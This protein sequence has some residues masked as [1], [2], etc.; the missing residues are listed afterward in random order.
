MSAPLEFFSIFDGQESVTYTPAVD[1]PVEGVLALRRPLTQSRM[2]NVERYV[3]LQATDV[4]FYLEGG[5]L[6]DVALAAGDSL[7]DDNGVAYQV[8]YV[9][10]QSLK[11]LV[12][13]VG[14]PV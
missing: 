3:Q 9:E 6:T 10:R 12:A 2:R 7:S 11:N 13:V 4:I 5:S 1:S 14:R 8:V